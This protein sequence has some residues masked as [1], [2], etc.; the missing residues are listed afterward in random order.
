MTA[1]LVLTIDVGTGSSRAC[2]FSARENRGLAV[3]AHENPVSHP[4]PHRAEFDPVRWWQ[5]ILRAIAEVVDKIGRPGGDYLGITVTSLRQGFVLLDRD[6]D[7]VAPGVLNYD[8]RGAGYIQA[9]ESYLDIEKLY[10]LTGH[11]HAPELTLPKLL[12]FRAERPDAWQKAASLL[13]VH[14]WVLY[15]LCGEK[16][17]NPTL[18]SAGQMANVQARTWADDLLLGLN[19]RTDLLPPVYEGGARLGSLRPEVARVVGLA[20]G[21]PVHVGGGDTQF[22]CLGVGAMAPGQV[23]IVG[24][25]TTPI[26]MTAERPLFDPLRY[27]WVSAHLR[28]GLWAIETNAGHTGMIYKWFRDTFGQVQV[29]QARRR[30]LGDYE[31]LDGLAANAPIGCEGLL[32]VATNPRWAQDTWQHRAPYLF[33]NFDVSHQLAHVARAILEGVCYGVRGNLEQLERVAGRR[34]ERISFTGGC[35]RAPLWAQMMTDVLGRPLCVPQVTEAAA[36]AGAQLV[37]WGQGSADVLPTPPVI[38]YEPDLMRTEQYEPYY[39]AYLEVF[40]KMQKHFGL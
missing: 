37:L 11:W 40:E 22:G 3:A 4:M 7:P 26:M 12:W 9:I 29:A 19:L 39:R 16:A 24:G 28:P 31:I 17:T 20:A 10:R 35:A 21:T 23:V 2:V 34:F 15:E 18:V 30:G 27:P 36:S 32:V 13:F 1:E 14:D 33:Y 5:A 8:R 38:L 25:S 6:G